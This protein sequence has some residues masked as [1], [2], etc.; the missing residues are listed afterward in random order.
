MNNQVFKTNIKN[1]NHYL[2]LTDFKEIFMKLTFERKTIQKEKI[3]LMNQLD[4]ENCDKCDFI[5]RANREHNIE[6]DSLL[7]ERDNVTLQ[8]IDDAIYRI[9]N[10]EDFGYCNC[11]GEEIGLK[12]LLVRPYTKECI[13]CKSLKEMDQMQSSLKYK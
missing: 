9:R 2:T 6:I 4:V 3:R 11:C 8:K 12:R 7:I 1:S 5:D 13:D 10:D